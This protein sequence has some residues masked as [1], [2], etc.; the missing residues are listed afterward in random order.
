MFLANP[1]HRFPEKPTISLSPGS[2]SKLI[3]WRYYKK[4]FSC[5]VRLP[6]TT[7]RLVSAVGGCVEYNNMTSF[8]YPNKMRRGM[9]YY[10]GARNLKML[11][12]HPVVRGVAKNPCD[13]P[14]GGTTN[15]IRLPRT[16]WGNIAKK[17][18]L[19]K[20]RRRWVFSQTQPHQF[21]SVR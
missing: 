20:E 15:S 6:S 2:C 5:Y 3:S 13:H 12:R 17:S 10:K 9:R 18:R 1:R 8:S 7:I 21:S 4:P 11:G 19:P 16:P 14:H